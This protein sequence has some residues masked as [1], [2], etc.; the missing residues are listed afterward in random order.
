M[1]K[2]FFGHLYTINK[3]RYWMLYYSSQAGITGRGLLHDLSKFHPTEFFEGVKY[4]N[5]KRSPVEISKEINGYSKAWLHHRGHNSHHY[6][7]WQ[8]NIDSGNKPI[9]MPYKDTVEMLCDYLAAGRTY[10]GKDFTF[11]K[12][13]DWWMERVKRPIAMHP[14]QRHFIR[15]ALT[16]MTATNKMLGP[17]DLKILYKECY[18]TY[19]K[20]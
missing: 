17:A 5:G 18:E 7:Y 13:L 11:Q 2:N 4:Y 12:E 8:I 9:C 19:E 14:V 1:I 15:I 6:D 3:H 16:C 20:K 10:L